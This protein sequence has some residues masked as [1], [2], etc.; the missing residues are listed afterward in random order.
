[1]GYRTKQTI[2]NWGILNR[3]EAPK[4]MFNIISLQENANQNNPDI[5][6]TPIR[7]AKIK[8]SGSSRCWQGCGER[9]TSF[10]AGGISSW[11]N[12]SGN[13]FVGLSENWEEIYQKTQLYTLGHI[14]K[15][16][17]TIP[18]GHILHYVNSS[19]IY[20]SQ[21]LERTQ[22][23]LNGRMYIECGAFTQWSTTQLLKLM[24][25]SIL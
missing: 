14:P 4:E 5:L 17:S 9:G 3:Q 19:L 25:L 18:R 15:R 12:H 8:N 13:Q 21:K 20:N 10:I 16:C 1:M 24:T 22:M 11:Y 7:M 23:S 6:L 2:F